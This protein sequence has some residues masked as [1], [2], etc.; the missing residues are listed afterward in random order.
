MDGSTLPSGNG[1]NMAEEI[2]LVEPEEENGDGNP[3]HPMSPEETNGLNCSLNALK[4]RIGTGCHATTAPRTGPEEENKHGNPC[5]PMS[6]EE[7]GGLNYAS[8]RL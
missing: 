3:C 2:K 1:K 6:P 7:T 4:K 5:H 8:N